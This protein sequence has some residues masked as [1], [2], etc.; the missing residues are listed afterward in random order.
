[1]SMKSPPLSRASHVPTLTASPSVA[2]Q[3]GRE[4]RAV[5]LV[6][7]GARLDRALA[8]V[9][10]D[11]SRSRVQALMGEG[12]V[13]RDGEVMSD[14]SARALAGVYRILIPP[15]RPADPEGEDIAL[16][17]CSKMSTLSSSTRP[18]ACRRTR[19]P[20]VRTERSS[21]P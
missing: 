15:A 19:R 6:E 18:P 7:A 5:E 8:D 9:L 20:A 17:I 14:L 1:M 2:S 3:K 11:L 16:D 10:P 13:T 12:A 4:E 21:T